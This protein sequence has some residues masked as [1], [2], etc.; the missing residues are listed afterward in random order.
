MNAFLCSYSLSYYSAK[1][2]TCTIEFV[3]DLMIKS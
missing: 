3:D 1:F 2:V